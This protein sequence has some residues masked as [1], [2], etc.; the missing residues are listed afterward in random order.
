MSKDF[1]NLINEFEAIFGKNWSPNYNINSNNK[2]GTKYI[3]YNSNLPSTN[4]FDDEWVYRYE[5]STP[6]LSKE[7]ITIQINGNKLT[8]S[9]ERSSN[10]DQKSEKGEYITK[11]YHHTKFVRSFE[12]PENVVS[13]EI[14]AKTENGITTIF[15][16]KEKPT[17]TKSYTRT[18][19]ID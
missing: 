3:G 1:L 6:G 8:F 16:P 10:S 12:I 18:V 14:H 13:D 4:V 17:K 9:G 15:L 7:D 11:E 19:S 5:L 2:N